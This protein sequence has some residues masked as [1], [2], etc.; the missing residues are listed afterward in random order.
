MPIFEGQSEYIF[1]PYIGREVT[2]VGVLNLG[3][4]GCLV[5]VQGRAGE[6]AYEKACWLGF[7]YKPSC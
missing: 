3:I 1:P 6:E 5:V 7:N 4:P 2:H